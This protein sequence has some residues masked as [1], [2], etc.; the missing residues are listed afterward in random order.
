MWQVRPNYL[1]ELRNTCGLFWSTVSFKFFRIFFA[2]CELSVSC[3]RKNDFF[4]RLDINR[5]RL[6]RRNLAMSRKCSTFYTQQTTA[7]N[8]LYDLL[9]P[10][11]LFPHRG[12]VVFSPRALAKLSGPSEPHRRHRCRRQHQTAPYLPNITCHSCIDHVIA[13]GLDPDK[14]SSFHSRFLQCYFLAR[15][16][17]NLL[18]SIN[19]TG[20][21]WGTKS[22]R[23]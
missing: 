10:R 4:S 15:R 1:S 18:H 5:E 22:H 13:R 9:P 8:G 19:T 16:R 21:G 20:V 11:F 3:Y 6:W 17:H 12:D 14:R 2:V 23:P 7:T